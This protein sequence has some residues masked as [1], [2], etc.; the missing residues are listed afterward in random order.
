MNP[1]K[2]ALL[3]DLYE[4]TMANAFYQELPKEEGVF[5]IF[6][7]NLPDNGS[8]VVLAGVKQAVE[9]V[10]K[11]HLSA[12]EL[13]YLRELDLFSEEFLAYLAD[14]QNQCEVWTIEEGTPVFSGES[15][16][17]VQ[18]PLI[19]AQ[20]YETMLLNLIN[21]QTLIASK[22]RRI[23]ASAKGRA[24]MEFGA[25]RAQGPDASIY[26]ARAT[27]IGGA[28]LTSNLLAGKKFN[29]PVAG[30]M[31]HSWIESFPTELAAFEAW[32]RQNPHN[33]SLLVDTY[34]V[35]NSGIPNAI[36][37]FEQ[38][39][40]K[41]V[42]ANIGIRI[43]SG[44]VTELTKKARKMLDQAGFTE[45]KITI[46]NA[47]D[48]YIIESILDEGAQVDNFGVGE[49]MITSSTSP[50][51]SGVYK[52]CAVKHEDGQVEPKIKVSASKTKVTLPGIKQVYR[53]YNTSG[54]A[55]ADVIALRDEKLGHSLSVVKADPLA[56]KKEHVLQDFIAK[57][58]LRPV[59]RGTKRVEELEG[60]VFKIQANSQAA[61]KELPAETK[62]LMNPAIFPV[63]VTS[64]LN[65]LQ[66]EMLAKH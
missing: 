42:D 31:A 32:A 63:Y 65:T 51:L 22:A 28:K 12:S 19:Q 17:T 43:D 60:D 15:V 36:K 14:F 8:F 33:C 11:F 5:D 30:T 21:H 41:G 53:L 4:L 64:K 2:L 35:L 54:Q 52:L 27:I 16:V 57:P 50:V 56:T 38:L 44:D 47:L 25:R 18:G 7:R 29:I 58:L 3:T 61:L 48:E 1:E 6:F 49:K 13:D 40:T 55:F 9:A 62:R 59:L 23:V 10:E 20:L 37:V 66:K 39:K 26:G 45:A 46:S 24:V 34:D